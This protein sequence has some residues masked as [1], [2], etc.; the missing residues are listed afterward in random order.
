MRIG[1]GWPKVFS[2]TFG[3]EEEASLGNIVG[4]APLLHHFV[5]AFERAI[6]T[7]SGTQ[8]CDARPHRQRGSLVRIQAVACED[9]DQHVLHFIGL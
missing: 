2:T 6:Q 3:E 1:Y 4:I 5:V 9:L 8:V 7:W